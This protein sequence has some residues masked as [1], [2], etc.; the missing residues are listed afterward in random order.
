[1]LDLVRLQDFDQALKA[2]IAKKDKRLQ[3]E[4]K[5]A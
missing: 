5:A 3:G 2:L 4:A 1:M